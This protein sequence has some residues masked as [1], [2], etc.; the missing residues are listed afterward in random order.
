MP[1]RILIVDAEPVVRSIV[2]AM[3]TTEG[4]EVMQTADPKAVLEIM[5]AEA[6]ALIITHVSLPGITG[7][8]AMKVFKENAP[9]VPVLMI[10]GLPDVEA[11]RQWRLEPGF[12]MFPK[13]FQAADLR[14]K[15]REMIAVAGSIQSK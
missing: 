5:K 11:I 1:I 9:H 8:E 10:S 3:L 6:P 7:H 12:G 14:A 4:Y 2:A 15:V 13:P